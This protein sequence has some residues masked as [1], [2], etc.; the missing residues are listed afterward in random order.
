MNSILLEVWGREKRKFQLRR[1]E[2]RVRV[3]RVGAICMFSLEDTNSGM[4]FLEFL[5]IVGD[6][7]PGVIV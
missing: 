2:I 5:V 4:Q 6:F 3:L 7:L 1:G